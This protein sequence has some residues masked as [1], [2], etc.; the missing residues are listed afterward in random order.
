MKS[1]FVALLVRWSVLALG[2]TLAAKVINGIHY[3]TL[4]TLLVVV[5]LLSLFNAV[6][7]PLLVLFSLPFIVLT[8]GLGMLIINALLFLLVGELV[9]G[10]IVDSFWSALGGA[11]IV[12]L[13]NVCV[14]VLFG[15]K[16]VQLSGSINVNRRGPARPVNDHSSPADSAQ[17]V[18]P[19]SQPRKIK[20]DDVIDI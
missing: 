1:P 9:Q 6:L 14:S 16:N 5:V 13:T 12:S 7:K 17:A 18:P 8:L 20:A 15:K 19:P 2:V 10:F 3:D 4:G 11:L